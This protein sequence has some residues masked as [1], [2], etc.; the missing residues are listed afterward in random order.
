M[1]SCASVNRSTTDQDV[2][3][4][5]CP[6]RTTLTH[7]SQQSVPFSSN[8]NSFPPFRS[9][10]ADI[11]DVCVYVLGQF[12]D[13]RISFEVATRS[14]GG[15]L[16]HNGPFTTTTEYPDRVT[17]YLQN[18]Q[19][20]AVVNLGAGDVTL[21]V[22]QAINDG[23]WHSIELI[24]QDRVRSKFLALLFNSFDDVIACCCG[25]FSGIPA[26]D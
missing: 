2:R 3:T 7:G 9:Q 6:S 11:T 15:V 16:L 4:R 22:G 24:K 10:F 1:V 14:S 19:V 25:F 12:I 17:I 26:G 21:S 23:T 18:G 8:P 5:K 13:G 20:R